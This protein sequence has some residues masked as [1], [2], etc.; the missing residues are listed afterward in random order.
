MPSL[1]EA[2]DYTQPLPRSIKMPKLVAAPKGGAKTKK[3]KNLENICKK[4]VKQ[5]FK[6]MNDS[7]APK[8]KRHR[9]TKQQ[10][11]DA[12][13]QEFLAK[14]QEEM[15]RIKQCSELVAS[16]V[17]HHQMKRKGPR[18]KIVNQEFHQVANIAFASSRHQKMFKCISTWCRYK[19]KEVQRFYNHLHTHHMNIQ[20]MTV[21]IHSFCAI[22]DS[23]IKANNFV[24]EF[25]HMMKHVNKAE[26]LENLIDILD[27]EI[28]PRTE[29]KTEI[30]DTKLDFEEAI[31]SS[32]IINADKYS[33]RSHFYDEIEEKLM[34][35]FDEPKQ[36][37]EKVEILSVETLPNIVTLK[38][39]DMIKVDDEMITQQTRK[40]VI[41]QTSKSII[42]SNYEPRELEEIDEKLCLDDLEDGLEVVEQ[43][44]VEFVK[45]EENEEI[46]EISI[47]DDPESQDGDLKIDIDEAITNLE[48]DI[49]ENCE[50]LSEISTMKTE[51][52]EEEDH[53]K[54]L[55]ENL[56]QRDSA[57]IILRRTFSDETPKVARNTTFKRSLSMLRNSD[58]HSSTKNSYFELN[59]ASDTKN[60]ER[61]FI[62]Q[63]IEEEK[64]SLSKRK[65]LSPREPSDAMCLSPI[66]ARQLESVVNYEASTSKLFSNANENPNN[67]KAVHDEK[68]TSMLRNS[69]QN[70]Q[71]SLNGLLKVCTS[72]DMT[73]WIEQMHL[74]INVKFEVCYHKM[75]RKNS[76]IALF[77]CM[78]M[79]CSFTTNDV[80]L[81]LNHLNCHH[82]DV[83]RSDN[84]HLYCAYCIFK[85]SDGKGL[86]HHINDIHSR[87]IYQ[88]S[89]CF[90][91]ARDKD[92]CCQHISLRHKHSDTTIYQCLG[93]KLDDRERKVVMER[94]KR[95]RSIFMAP[96]RCKCEYFF[97]TE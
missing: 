21:T 50:D 57:R 81:F 80:E 33:D 96:I 94:L 43:K 11:I 56:E 36:S 65:S 60:L 10:I 54:N 24:D 69:S 2:P 55:I 92:A 14:Q 84:F 30:E 79:S 89:R 6:S 90:Y 42:E 22:C 27:P 87:D 95:K 93:P 20:D 72:A 28:T 58:S 3:R 61:D 53:Y 13:L 66:T 48:N 16:T 41:I 77:K 37:E 88:C 59:K 17:S 46:Q 64:S 31:D 68:E 67:S 15:E 34:L 1:Q 44:P 7:F 97:G 4:K 12:R 82:I 39:I 91:R 75:L 85:A 73:P 51:Q 63:L 32:V 74:R 49:S 19:T 86:A 70:H 35:I 83:K 18:M 62:E 45:V 26:N 9:R 47:L 8:K 40:N 52:V 38:S 76:L 5:H 23:K 25:H 78:N 71:S 29:I